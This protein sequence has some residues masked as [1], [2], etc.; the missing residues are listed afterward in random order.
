[1]DR[2]IVILGFLMLV[3]S[4]TAAQLAATSRP[5]VPAA[6]DVGLAKPVARING[7]VLTEADLEHEMSAMFPYAQ[8]HG[9][10][11]PKSMEA[12]VRRGAL[13]MIEFEELVYQEAVRQNMHISP[14]R[15][16]RAIE[17]LR[18]QF[19]S[20]LAFQHFIKTEFRGSRAV[21]RQKAER[22]LLID[23][24]LDQEVTKKSEI[25]NAEVRSA[26]DHDPAKF[27]VSR[28]VSIQTI[29]VVIPDDA[30][31]EQ[32]ITAH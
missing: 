22:S 23:E 10:K 31:P 30:T 21:L 16:D 19:E 7:A 9:G 27:A 18:A 26:Y 24:L 12:E 1:M 5:S 8:Q 28:R 4:T 20:E 14:A 29:S 15:L 11:V 3:A 32:E 2:Y 25:S 17:D 6:T 13:Q